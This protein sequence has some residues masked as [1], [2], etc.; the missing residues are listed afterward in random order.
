MNIAKTIPGTRS[1]LTIL[2]VV[3]L[4]SGCASA[5][6]STAMIPATMDVGTTH[7]HSVNVV[8]TGGA[9]TTAMQPS[10]ISNGAFKEA[11][12][13]SLNK[14]HAFAQVGETGTADYRLQVSIFSIEQPSIGFSMTVKMEAGWTLI[15]ERTKEIVWRESVQS[16]YTASAG[17]AFSGAER[18]RLATEGAARENIKQAIQNLSRVDI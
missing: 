16:T 9:E 8:V 6:V 12:V 15:Q 14:S 11:I 17:A 13:D 3:L 7:P 18:I 1:I 5:A 2:A 10:R 4:M